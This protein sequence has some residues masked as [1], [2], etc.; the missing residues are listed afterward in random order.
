M[1]TD[2]RQR[3]SIGQAITTFTF[4]LF[5]V[6]LGLAALTEP[7]VPKAVLVGFCSILSF[8]GALRFQ[9]QQAVRRVRRSE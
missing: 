3:H 4:I 6:L 7:F 5:G 9:I 8:L 1:E 2:T